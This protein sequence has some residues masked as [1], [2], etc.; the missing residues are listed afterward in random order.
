[1]KCTYRSSL[2]LSRAPA[3]LDDKV[4]GSVR[5]I[6]MYLE[7][8]KFVFVNV[9]TWLVV[10]GVV[11]RDDILGK[12]KPPKSPHHDSFAS[13]DDS[14]FS[15]FKKGKDSKQKEWKKAGKYPKDPSLDEN[16]SQNVSMPGLGREKKGK[17][18]KKK[19]AGGSFRSSDIKIE[20]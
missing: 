8:V 1:M 14:L 19:A 20:N 16:S 11:N 18:G 6:S 9:V 5:A 3:L 15:R 12:F 10:L 17:G 4:Y 13:D 2:T 7:I